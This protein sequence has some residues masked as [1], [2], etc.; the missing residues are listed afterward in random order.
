MAIIDIRTEIK[1]E[2]VEKAMKQIDPGYC[3]AARGEW[4]VVDG[5]KVMHHGH[6]NWTPWPG[7]ASV[8]SVE[9]LVFGLGGITYDEMRLAAM[10]HADET[11][12]QAHERVTALLLNAIPPWYD[13]ATLEQLLHPAGPIPTEQA[14]MVGREPAL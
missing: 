8:I 14:R 10:P 3:R 1:P 13:T 9:D 4:F 11:D 5:E 2:I 6:T 7:T 12:A